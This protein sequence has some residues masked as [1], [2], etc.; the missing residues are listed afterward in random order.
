MGSSMSVQFTGFVGQDAVLKEV[1]EQR[2][3]SFS[4]AVNRQDQQ[5]SAADALG[6]GQRLEWSQR[7]GHEVCPQ[8]LA[9]PG[10]KFVDAVERM[11]RQER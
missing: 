7:C 2:V 3:A 5:R 10:R 4:L 11:D 9:D 1:G 6:T 8:V